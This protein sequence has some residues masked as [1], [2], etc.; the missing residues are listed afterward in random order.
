[1]F[2]AD[3]A[4]LVVQHETETTDID[5]AWHLLNGCIRQR[6][7]FQGLQQLVPAESIGHQ[8]TQQLNIGFGPVQG[9]LWSQVCI[10][11]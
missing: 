1:M 2:N 6:G 5:P 7:V 4:L 3:N 11:E 10:S 9:N 8:F